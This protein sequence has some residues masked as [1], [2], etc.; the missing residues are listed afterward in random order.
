MFKVKK[1]VSDLCV[2]RGDLIIVNDNRYLLVVRTTEGLNFI[3][4]DDDCNRFIDET[5]EEK[6]SFEVLKEKLTK[7][8]FIDNIRLIKNDDYRVI[9][10]GDM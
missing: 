9:L 7:L 2:E 5:F 10:E 8:S 1:Q 3:T 4:L 6:I